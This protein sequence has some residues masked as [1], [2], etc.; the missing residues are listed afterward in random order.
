MKCELPTPTVVSPTKTGLTAWASV[1]FVAKP[2][3]ASLTLMT[4][5]SSGSLVVEPTLPPK[6]VD[7]IWILSSTPVTVYLTASPLWKKW[8]GRVIWFVSVL[9]P[10]VDDPSNCLLKMSSPLCFSSNSVATLDFVPK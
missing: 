5:K 1:G 7:T 4:N 9:T 8:F 6:S 2:I 3:E 10:T